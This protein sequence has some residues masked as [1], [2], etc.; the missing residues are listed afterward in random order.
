[1]SNTACEFW[2]FDEQGKS[3]EGR[4]ACNAGQD[5][6]PLGEI[7]IGLNLLEDRRSR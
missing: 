1:M 4:D 6:E 2:H 3:C 5:C 7:R